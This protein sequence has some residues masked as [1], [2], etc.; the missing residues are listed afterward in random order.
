MTDSILIG[1]S[2][3]GSTHS[4]NYVPFTFLLVR[5]FFVSLAVSTPHPNTRAMNVLRA[6]YLT[7][8]W[9]ADEVLKLILAVMA[10]R[11]CLTDC[12]NNPFM[13]FV[14]I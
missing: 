1:K 11:V 13:F 2:I 10:H 14:R 6:S 5:T 12:F 8:D 3:E 9:I 7:W 4:F